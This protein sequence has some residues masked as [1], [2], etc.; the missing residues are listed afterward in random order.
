MR[1]FETMPWSEILGRHHH[2][3]A[4]NDIIQPAQNRLEQLGYDDQAELVSFRLSNTERIWAIRS[5]A[6]AFLIWWDPNHEIYPSA[7]KHT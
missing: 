2:A 1:N 4:V 7:P 3:I 6:E 5:G